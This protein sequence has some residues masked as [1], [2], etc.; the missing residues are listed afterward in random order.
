MN[1]RTEHIAA[2]LRRWLERF[3]PPANIKDNP[4]AAQDSADA[5]LKVLLRFAP[6]SAYEPWVNRALDQT[7]WQMKTRAW[8]TVHE[9]GA[10]CSNMRKDD[11]RAEVEQ[12][13][14]DPFESAAHRIREGK[15]VG[16]MWLYGHHAHQI[17]ARGRGARQDAGKAAVGRTDDRDAVIGIDPKHPKRLL[18]ARHRSCDPPRPTHPRGRHEGARAVRAAHRAGDTETVGA[19]AGPG[20]GQRA[21][22]HLIPIGG[23]DM[24]DIAKARRIEGGG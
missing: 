8:P 7:E 14:A 17:V 2:I 10:V 21:T 16:D 19:R 15:P 18:P 13:K 24:P 6:Q 22:A 9:I 11:P 5:L 4:R 3:S 23:H 1:Q 12:E 20:L